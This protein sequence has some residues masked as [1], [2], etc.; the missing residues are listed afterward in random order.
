VRAAGRGGASSLIKLA[1]KCVL[2]VLCCVLVL[3]LRTRLR[4]RVQHGCRAEVDRDDEVGIGQLDRDGRCGATTNPVY[5]RRVNSLEAGI[6]KSE[7]TS[8]IGKIYNF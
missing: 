8:G 3:C 4:A 5:A 7:H 2:C 1:T 6:C